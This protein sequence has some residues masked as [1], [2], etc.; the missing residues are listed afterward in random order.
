MRF[1]LVLVLMAGLALGQK[2]DRAEVQL[3]G[4]IKK[5]VVD[6]DLKGAIEQYKK[7]IAANRGNHAVAAKALV[8]LGQ[9][10]EK[11]GDAE[12]RMAYDQVLHDYSDRKDL[13]ETARTRLVAL[14]GGAKKDQ[15]ATRVVW[16]GA[17]VSADGKLSADG[18]YLSTVDWDTGDL[19]IHDFSTGGDRRL[20]NK[21]TWAQSSDYAE[22]SVL[23][24]DAGQ[25]SYS[26]YVAANDRYE[27]RIANIPASGLVQPRHLFGSEDVVWIVPKDWSHDGAW[28]LV[29]IL[30]KDRN[31]QVGLV[32]ARDGSLRVL[33]SGTEFL[34]AGGFSHDGNY[35]VYTRRGSG[36]VQ[37]SYI[38]S[39]DG[40]TES[41]LIPGPASVGPCAW[42]PDGSRIVFVSERGGASGLWA[43]RIA[44]G[45]TQGEAELL[46]RDFR[47]N[48]LIGFASDGSLFTCGEPDVGHLSRGLGSR[49]G[50]SDFRAEAR[51]PACCWQLVGPNRLAPGRMIVVVLEQAK[52]ARLSCGPHARHR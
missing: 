8:Q 28:L 39:L 52:R 18:R 49:Q 15:E 51:Q 17:N 14:G 26:W 29:E 10:Y 21:G 34:D 16:T 36:A 19:A 13:A 47:T 38:L 22:E 3:A 7:I 48:A 50:G 43:V 4:A 25:I 1:T 45:K 44:D 46:K 33:R 30:R 6:G 5:E 41:P 2:S 31:R 11:L 20:T 9:C 40:K 32:S 37:S 12:A 35:I 42:T 27:L 24:A 23:S